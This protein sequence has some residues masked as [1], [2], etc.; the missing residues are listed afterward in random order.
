MRKK[1]KAILAV[2]VGAFAFIMVGA[3][4]TVSAETTLSYNVDTVTA[5]SYSANDELYKNDIATVVA[6]KSLNVDTNNSAATANDDSGLTFTKGLNPTGT[7]TNA[8][9]S[10]LKVTSATDG[11][12][13]GLYYTFSDSNFV[14]KDQSKSASLC[15]F[16]DS[17]TLKTFDEV[18][19]SN[20]VAY[21]SEYSISGA[22]T[23]VYVGSSANR[24]IVMGFIIKQGTATKTYNVTIKNALDTNT[25]LETQVVE[26]KGT[27]SFNKSIWGYDFNGLYTD[28]NCQT[29]YNLETVTGD[30]VL[31]ANYNAWDSSKIESSYNLTNTLVSEISDL[32][33]LGS[34]VKLTGTIYT[35]M[36]NTNYATSNNT[37]CITTN[38]KV[39]TSE[40]ALKIE[41]PS[42]GMISTL[43]T[44][45]GSSSRSAS[46]I[47]SK[48]SAVAAATGNTSWTSVEAKAYEQRII[49]YKVS[50]GTYYLGGS[51]GM[52]ILNCEFVPY[53]VIALQQ[54]ATS[55]DYT[56]VRFITKITG[57]ADVTTTEATK[58]VFTMTYADN[59]TKEVDYTSHMYIAD[60]IKNNSE[61][62]TATVND[63]SYTFANHTCEYY[64]V[65]VVRLTTA[66]FNG[67]KIHAT[68]T[69]GGNT[70]T[71]TDGTIGN[72]Q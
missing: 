57:V 20:K 71:S 14:K 31:Y 26:E 22:S 23:T 7:S 28:E 37:S 60:A 54:E 18:P 11:A 32:Y 70:Y 1:L 53:S 8:K 35:L 52:R 29:S 47:D 41:V 4:A 17:V 2:I 9:G 61:D 39:S 13:I 45:G 33:N 42:D 5:T 49:T 64:V 59:S 62:Y 36:E 15:I 38:K 10:V 12:T 63:S 30:T 69:Y 66:K 48:G 40:N 50:A 44:T 43:I 6:N 68:L 3:T 24:L 27:V 72:A 16:N 25:T 67:C 19:G 56:Y 46:L 34:E 21:Y 51:N 55:G 58:L 65:C